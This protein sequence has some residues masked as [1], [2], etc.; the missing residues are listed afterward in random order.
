MINNVE[1]LDIVYIYITVHIL[2]KVNLLLF[3]R[4]VIDNGLKGSEVIIRVEMVKVVSCDSV[5]RKRS[6][7]F[8][9]NLNRISQAG[10][11]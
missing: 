5:L 10:F 8:V 11:N 1:L 6:N 7:S 4:L 2:C 9:E 3:L